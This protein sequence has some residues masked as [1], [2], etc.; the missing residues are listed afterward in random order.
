MND[1]R[2]TAA[3][4][5]AGAVAVA[6]YAWWA[7][8]LPAFSAAASAGVLGAGAAAVAA[9]A[10]LRA[11]RPSGPAPA[12]G[13]AGVVPWFVLAG[14]LAALQLVAYLGQPRAEHPTL[15]Y[16]ANVALDTQAA[17]A[18]AFVAWLAAAVDLAR[19]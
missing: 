12:T 17:R 14:A 9:G 6:A 1:V 3:I 8:G 2:R 15:S 11:R 13:A 7:V 18:A 5:A 4:G 16:L 10:R 19:R